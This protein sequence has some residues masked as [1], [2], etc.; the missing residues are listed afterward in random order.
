MSNTDDRFHI[1]GYTITLIS[2]S[3]GFILSLALNEAFKTTFTK[4]PL[5]K[6]NSLLRDWLYFLTV[7]NIVI[8]ALYVINKYK[9][10]QQ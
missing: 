7:L 8:F 9:Q 3:L 6:H 5:G 1:I 10:K 4:I 2:T